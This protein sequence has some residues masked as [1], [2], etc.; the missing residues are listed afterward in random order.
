MISIIVAMDENNVIGLNNDLPWK[1][2]EDLKLF[3]SH[4]IGKNIIMGRNT[5]VSLRR[6]TGLPKRQNIVV[7]K[8]LA[9]N[10]PE[11][12]VG[13]IF[14]DN[15]KDAMS[16]G[17]SLSQE[18]FVIG[19]ERMYEESLSHAD[20]LYISFV[21]EPADDGD[22]FFPEINWDEWE[23]IELQEYDKFIFKKYKRI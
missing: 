16:F 12:A 14:Q 20:Y 18:V 21:K 13:V 15:F 11:L 23:E 1:I 3:K 9:E 4:T 19:G 2:P 17:K 7:S 8:T 10:K 6:P 22:T 5:Y